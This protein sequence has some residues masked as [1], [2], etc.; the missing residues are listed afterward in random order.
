MKIPVSVII[1]ARNEETNVR[2]CIEPVAFADEVLVVDSQC[3]GNA[4]RIADRADY[5][6]QRQ[7]SGVARG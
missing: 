7:Q 1:P 2:P 3:I 6:I 4:C 5:G